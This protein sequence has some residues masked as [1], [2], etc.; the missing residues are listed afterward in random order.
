LFQC[1]SR[2]DDGRASPQ[3]QVGA[4]RS[5]ATSGANDLP[6][7]PPTPGPTRA[8]AAS[9]ST[10]GPTAGG[11]SGPPQR[12]HRGQGPTATKGRLSPLGTGPAHG[13]TM[14]TT[15]SNVW[16]LLQVL[17][18]PAAKNLVRMT[19]WSCLVW[20][21][22]LLRPVVHHICGRHPFPQFDTGDSMTC[23]E[24]TTKRL[25]LFG[26]DHR[27][28]C[29]VGDSAFLTAMQGSGGEGST[30][31]DHHSASKDHPV[32]PASGER[33][34]LGVSTQEVGALER[35]KLDD[36]PMCWST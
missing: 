10:S 6:R 35:W 19:R 26:G 20:D 31:S 33:L 3:Q 14:T 22:G 15:D 27:M 29:Y 24:L 11:S 4:A 2:A 9:C 1:P 7:S 13:A 23:R 12:P 32:A 34:V 17:A 28:G 30:G 25:K 21:H 8:A 5:P 36:N 18:Q 16:G